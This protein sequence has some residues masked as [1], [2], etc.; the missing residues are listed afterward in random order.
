MNPELAKKLEKQQRRPNGPGAV[1]ADLLETSG[2][3]QS[4]F[5][6]RIGVSNATVNRLINAHQA[7]SP[8]M[9]LRLGRFWGDGSR[10]WMAHQ[11]MVDLWDLTHADQSP[12]E[13]I[14]PLKIAA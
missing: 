7:L 2:M 3:S 9:A 14:E 8:D 12:Y 1:L 11:Q 5:A 10:V 13:H 6:R 4:E